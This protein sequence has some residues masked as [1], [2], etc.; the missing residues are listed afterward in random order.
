MYFLTVDSFDKR[1][2]MAATNPSQK[3]LNYIVVENLYIV[4]ILYICILFCPGIPFRTGLPYD[5]ALT[6]LILQTKATVAIF[7]IL[8]K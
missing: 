7:S 1:I 8:K 6:A 2:N 3:F 4:Y 5:I